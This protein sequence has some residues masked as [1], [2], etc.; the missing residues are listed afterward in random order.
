MKNLSKLL[1]IICALFGLNAI[2]MDPLAQIYWH[3]S[4]EEAIKQSQLSK[5]PV[6]M[7]FT[8]SDWCYSCSKL[9]SEVIATP[10]FSAATFDKFVFLIIDFTKK[11]KMAPNLAAQASLLQNKYG[12][13]SLPTILLIDSNGKKICSLGYLATDAKKYA[14]QL[15]QLANM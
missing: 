11:T 1:L 14:E 10:E 8:G 7:L 6:L 9:K 2:S 13:K 3:T 4:Y 5:K 12:V 15:L